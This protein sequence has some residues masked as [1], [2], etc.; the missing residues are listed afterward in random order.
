MQHVGER[1]VKHEQAIDRDQ[2]VHRKLNARGAP[3]E[4]FAGARGTTRLAHN[5]CTSQQYWQ[6][7]WRVP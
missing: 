6:P 3:A 1:L 2:A 4:R 7:A 5:Q